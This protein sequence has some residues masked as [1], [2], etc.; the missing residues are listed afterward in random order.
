M[1]QKKQC[2]E[3]FFREK[4]TALIEIIL[5]ACLPSQWGKHP[6]GQKQQCPLDTYVSV[7]EAQFCP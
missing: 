3:I 6:L 1:Y 2:Q 4:E 5:P 7:E